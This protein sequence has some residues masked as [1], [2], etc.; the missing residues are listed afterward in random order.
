MEEGDEEVQAVGSTYGTPWGLFAPSTAFVEGRA[1]V[2]H[3]TA[4]GGR[5]P[6]GWGGE[7]HPTLSLMPVCPLPNGP[8]AS[9]SAI[10]KWPLQSGRRLSPPGSLA[11]RSAMVRPGV[12]W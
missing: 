12:L 2:W 10:R 11:P 8:G 6:N 7:G 4:G 9:V 1:T 5:A 3:L